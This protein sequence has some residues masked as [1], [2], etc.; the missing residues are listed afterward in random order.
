VL[1]KFE[2]GKGKISGREGV[3]SQGSI[4]VCESQT[5]QAQWINMKT[6]WGTMAFWGFQAKRERATGRGVISVT[7]PEGEERR[8]QTVF[9]EDGTAGKRV[10]GSRVPHRNWHPGSFPGG[11][12]PP[13]LERKNLLYGFRGDGRGGGEGRGRQGR[14]RCTEESQTK[15]FHLNSDAGTEF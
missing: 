8:I 4:V 3:T 5:R 15:G 2:K 12:V 9:P 6:L 14:K 10:G 1:I 13:F 11:G 7:L